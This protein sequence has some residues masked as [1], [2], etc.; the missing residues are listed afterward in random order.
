MIKTKTYHL[1]CVKIGLLSLMNRTYGVVILVVRCCVK[2][3]FLTQSFDPFF[4]FW[5]LRLKKG[6]W[7]LI[8]CLILTDLMVYKIRALLHYFTPCDVSVVSCFKPFLKG[9]VIYPVIEITCWWLR[10]QYTN[11]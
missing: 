7:S 11:F 5:N 2:N 10:R 3:K 6:L 1:H 4:R 9:T 8:Y